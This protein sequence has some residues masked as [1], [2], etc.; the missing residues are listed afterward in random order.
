MSLFQRYQILHPMETG[1]GVS[2]YACR[3]PSPDSV[4]RVLTLAPHPWDRKT[5]EDYFLIR[6][7][8]V[9]PFL[10][11]VRDVAHRGRRIGVVSDKIP[12][13]YA[14]GALDRVSDKNKT[15][16]LPTVLYALP[17][18]SGAVRKFAKPHFPHP[19]RTLNRGPMKWKVAGDVKSPSIARIQ[20]PNPKATETEPGPQAKAKPRNLNFR[21]G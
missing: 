17:R 19:G 5:F 18:V 20:K 14:A 1:P 2:V 16:P 21:G 6:K 10:V 9:S 4:E 3:Q 12:G 11:R 15:K 8:L 7:E 13:E